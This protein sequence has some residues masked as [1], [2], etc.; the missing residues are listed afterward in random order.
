MND[1]TRERVNQ[2]FRNGTENFSEAD[3]KKVM[4][5]SATAESKAGKL[6]EQFE[7][8]KLLWGLLKDY[9]NKEYSHAPWK[10]IATMQNIK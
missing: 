10:L 6:G 9:H 8:F 2:A 3:L 1:K 7:N 4:E 5:D